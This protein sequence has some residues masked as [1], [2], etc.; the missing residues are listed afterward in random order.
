M[1]DVFNELDIFYGASHQINENLVINHPTVGEVKSF[2]EEQYYNAISIFFSTPSDYKVQLFDIGKDYTQIDE[3]EMFC[4]LY[5][6]LREEDIK[7]LFKG[8]KDFCLNKFIP[9]MNND[10]QIVL[11]SD[12]SDIFIDRLNYIIISSFIKKINFIEKKNHKAGNEHSKEYFIERERRRQ[13]HAQTKPF[14]SILLP[15]ISTLVNDNGFKYDHKTVLDLP[16]YTFYDSVR[17]IQRSKNVGHI[18]NGMYAGT[19]DSKN[20]SHKD[21]SIIRNAD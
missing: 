2:G 15:T 11:W 13:K 4:M 7:F 1:A 3:F 21:L 17:E 18:F 12:E 5:G 14:K 6:S 16:I 10:N 19:I 8:S 9:I 20:I